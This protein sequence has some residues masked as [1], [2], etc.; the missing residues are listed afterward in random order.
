VPTVSGEVVNEGEEVV[1]VAAV[2]RKRLAVV[3]AM[4]LLELRALPPPRAADDIESAV[5]IEIAGACALGPVLVAE[6][7]LLEGR[8]GVAPTNQASRGAHDQET[9]HEKGRTQTNGGAKLQ[10]GTRTGALR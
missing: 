1:G 8:R 6:P 5:T 10:V 3:D 9:H 7:T 2:V 4:A